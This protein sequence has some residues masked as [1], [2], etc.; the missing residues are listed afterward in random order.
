MLFVDL[1]ITVK[2]GFKL[3]REWLDFNLKARVGKQLEQL[4]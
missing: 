3:A 4:G 2:Q 1:L